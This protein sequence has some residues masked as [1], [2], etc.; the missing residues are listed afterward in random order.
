MDIDPLSDTGPPRHAIESDDEDDFNPLSKSPET[1]QPEPVF[2]I[3]GSNATSE[4]LIVAAGDAGRVWA[5]G[6]NLGEQIGSVFI[7]KKL[8]GLVFKPTWTDAIA[9]ISE[10]SIR[11]PTFVIHPYAQFVL[12][13]YKP[14]SL[15][16]L[17]TYSL[18]GYIGADYTPFYRAPLRYL[19]TGKAA[20]STSGIQLFAPPN[21]IQSTSASFLSIAALIG[22]SSKSQATAFLL[23]SPNLPTRPPEII[24]SDPSKL[25]D[26][27]D[28]WA[29]QLL[30]QAHTSIVQSVGGKVEA[31]KS[32]GK[33]VTVKASSSRS[34][35][36]GSM[37]I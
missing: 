33:K 26:E 16:L 25:V 23:P 35:V 27:T 6:A 30:Q 22:I 4:H 29:D 17:D 36:D 21:L 34:V 12:E 3:V 11:L 18:P 37:Y 7:D 19:S 10:V 9:I 1:T 24:V 13:H 14:T 5:R 8:I 31:W 2:E 15:I 28:I 32:T 20:S